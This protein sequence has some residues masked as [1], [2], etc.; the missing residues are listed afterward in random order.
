MLKRITT[1]VSLIFATLCIQSHCN[2]SI[3]DAIAFH[4]KIC[5][6]YGKAPH[7]CQICSELF[8]NQDNENALATEDLCYQNIFYAN[9]SS[10][11][12]AKSN[13]P[14]FKDLLTKC[15]AINDTDA[16]IACFQCL[17]TSNNPE[18]CELCFDIQNNPFSQRTCFQAKPNI[19]TTKDDLQKSIAEC[20][21]ADQ[22]NQW[23]CFLCK[24]WNN[25]NSCTMY[26]QQSKPSIFL[27]G[28]FPSN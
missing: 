17:T 15:G 18:L 21:K 4:I 12:L 19:V 8:A 14:Q 25:Q 27:P 9:K 1:I 11:E 2:S 10:Q 24:F 20:A 26:D 6:Q 3:K 23:N 16:Q 7:L 5:G 22:S 13:L 28:W